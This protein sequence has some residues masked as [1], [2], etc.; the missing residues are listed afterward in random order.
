MAR[1]VGKPHVISGEAKRP[2]PSQDVV[3]VSFAAIIPNVRARADWDCVVLPTG[4]KERLA[5]QAAM[6][7]V[8]R[9]KVEHSSLP[10]HGVIGLFGPPG[11]G[12]TTLAR[13]LGDAVSRVVRG[14]GEFLL[15]EVDAHGL[16]GAMLGRSQ[17]AVDSLFRDQVPQWGEE[18]PVVLVL[19][20]VETIAADRS[21]LSLEANPFDVHRAS[22]AALVG[23]DYLGRNHPEVM[24]IVTS[25][26]AG[27]VDPALMSRVDVAYHA[28]L[29]DA[30][31]VEAI[32]RDTIAAVARAFPNAERVATSARFP[33]AIAAAVGL[34]GR[35]IR[36]TVAAAC[37]ISDGSDLDPGKLTIEDLLLAIE[38]SKA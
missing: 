33:E 15:V 26:F 32:L 37:S 38:E 7:F 4:A 14:L 24:V 8:L 6:S 12:K 17:K 35:R 27:A 3:G 9:Q 18:G 2:V 22:D 21:K 13:G 28:P 30:A 34:D 1:S 19:D 36:K 5:R 20:E 29:P 10:L 16:S 23:L 31:A 11:T 25:N